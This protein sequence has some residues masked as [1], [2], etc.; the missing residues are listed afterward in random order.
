MISLSFL[1]KRINLLWHTLQKSVT[2][3]RKCM[4]FYFLS[5]VVRDLEERARQIKSRMRPGSVTPNLSD[6][7]AMRIRHR[8][9]YDRSISR[10][11]GYPLYDRDPSRGRRKGTTNTRL[12]ISFLWWHTSSSYMQ[13]ELCQQLNLQHNYLNL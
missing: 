12:L 7:E 10:E 2:L 11:R 9:H 13:D 5:T 3:A 4:S 1:R 8:S 6:S